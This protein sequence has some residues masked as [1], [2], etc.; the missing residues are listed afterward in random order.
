ME[1]SDVIAT[2]AAVVSTILAIYEILRN[3]KKLRIVIDYE[4]FTNVGYLRLINLSKRPIT[5]ASVS[6]QL[7]EDRV[8]STSMFEDDEGSTILPKILEEYSSVELRLTDF[9]T[10]YIVNEKVKKFSIMVFDI[11]GK[12][13]SKYKV[14]EINSRWGGIERDM[15]NR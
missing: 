9:V 5:V 11:E 13:Y 12:V 2:Y 8:P 10:Q 4:C 6:M 3:T 7:D 15:F 1:L 14:R